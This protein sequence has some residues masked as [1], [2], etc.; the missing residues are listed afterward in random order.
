V[1]LLSEEEKISTS[2]Q[3]LSEIQKIAVNAKKKK[4]TVEVN[5]FP[6]QPF[7][8][9]TRPGGLVAD[10]G[11]GGVNQKPDLAGRPVDKVISKVVKK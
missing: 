5:N 8:V 3:M 7:K 10:W 2:I 4:I 9:I 6:G 1:E 11:I